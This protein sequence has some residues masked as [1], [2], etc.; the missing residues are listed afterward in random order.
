MFGSE[1]LNAER[2]TLNVESLFLPF[3]I[4]INHL[5]EPVKRGWLRSSAKAVV[6]CGA[7]PDVLVVRNR[8]RVPEIAPMA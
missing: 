2:R 8:V 3:R 4:A 5:V 6:D 7:L 1:T